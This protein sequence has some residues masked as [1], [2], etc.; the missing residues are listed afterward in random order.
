MDAFD[1]THLCQKDFNSYYKLKQNHL[2]LERL[3]GSRWFSYRTPSFF[4]NEFFFEVFKIFSHHSN[5]FEVWNKNPQK[6]DNAN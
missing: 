6:L 3:N 2:L 1:L 5:N 4:G